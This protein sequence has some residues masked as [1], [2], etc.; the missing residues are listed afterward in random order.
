MFYGVYYRNNFY[1]YDKL[2]RL[3]FDHFMF[4]PTGSSWT[5]QNSNGKNHFG[6]R[7]SYDANGNILSLSRNAL[8]GGTVQKM[9]SLTYSYTPN[10]N[11][12]SH[13]TDAITPSPFTEDLETQSANNYSYDASGNLIEDNAEQLDI[14]WNIKG[15]VTKV[16]DNSTPQKI[17][18]FEYDANGNR[19]KKKVSIANGPCNDN[20]T[21]YYVYADKGTL[22][23]TYSRQECTPNTVYLDEHTLYGSKRLG[24]RNYPG[25]GQSNRVSLDNVEVP[26]DQILYKREIFA[27]HYEV[28]DHLGNVRA[29]ISDAKWSYNG[30]MTPHIVSY[31]NYYPFGMAQPGRNWSSGGYRFGYNGVEKDDEIKGSGNSYNFEFRMHDP[32]KA[33][34][35]AIDPMAIQYPE[36]SP[37]VFANNCVIAFKEIDG[38]VFDYAPIKPRFDLKVSLAKSVRLQGMGL[39]TVQIATPKYKE[40][41][42]GKEINEYVIHVKIDVQYHEKF[43]PNGKG[44][45]EQANKG[46]FVEVEAH[47]SG[48]VDIIKEV[49]EAST[50]SYSVKYNGKTFKSKGKADKVLTEIHNFLLAE[51]TIVAEKMLTENKSREEIVKKRMEV[52]KIEKDAAYAIGDEIQSRLNDLKNKENFENNEENANQRATIKLNNNTPWLNNSKYFNNP[53]K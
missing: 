46:L 8:N 52:S 26:N 18:S 16:T 28:S 11:R 17:I 2:D 38:A 21:T 40:K 12:L 51:F 32:R 49:V 44:P 42:N 20:V 14:E 45:L 33:R 19:V 31:T 50:Y 15:K 3:L 43:S 6:S 41:F 1:T 48:H 10:T 30:I 29:V 5:Y 53:D 37:Y 7:Y 22:L 27:K 4:R 23:A 34:W 13:L 47:E 35:D 24:V 9:D 25:V 39:T 36:L